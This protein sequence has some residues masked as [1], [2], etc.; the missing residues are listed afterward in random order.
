MNF[1]FM[2]DALVPLPLFPA[3]EKRR[4]YNQAT[5]LCE[6]MSA[7]LQVPVLQDLVTRSQY[8]ESQTQKGRIERWKNVDGKFILDSK[9]VIDHKHL[10]LVDDVVTTGATLEACGME[11]L[12]AGNV[13]LS[14]AAL[15]FATH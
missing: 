9:T 13:Q 1:C 4:G 10:L 2:I 7:I 15:C 5:V 11:L 8:T 14:L 3:K 6:G 12:K